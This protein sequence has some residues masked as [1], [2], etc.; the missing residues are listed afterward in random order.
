[1][2]VVRS[3]W[4][5]AKGMPNAE[6]QQL[7]KGR[8]RL[9]ATEADSHCSTDKPRRLPSTWPCATPVRQA[10]NARP[11]QPPRRPPSERDT[12]PVSIQI[13][14]VLAGHPVIDR[15]PQ[16][17]RETP[18][19][20]LFYSRQTVRAREHNAPPARPIR[21]RRRNVVHR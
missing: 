3:P 7:E 19:A 17:G 2:P 15:R 8:D 12:T 5:F 6:S 14:H 4:G 21:P 11:L 10:S 9:A 16:T 18:A 1:M 13:P 20:Q